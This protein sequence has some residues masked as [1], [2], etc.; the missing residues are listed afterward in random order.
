MAQMLAYYA[1]KGIMPS[2]IYNASEGEKM[3][4]YTAMTADIE[5]REKIIERLSNQGG[6]GLIAAALL[7]IW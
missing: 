5:R 3:F 4:L 2:V 6:A 1:R 7:D